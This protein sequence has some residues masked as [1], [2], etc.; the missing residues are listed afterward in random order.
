MDAQYLDFGLVAV[1]DSTCRQLSIFNHSRCPVKFR[2]SQAVTGGQQ[3]ELREDLEWDEKG[4]PKL[5]ALVLLAYMCVCMCASVCVCFNLVYPCA[6]LQDVPCLGFN[7]SD[8]GEIA[9]E[10]G[11]M[12]EVV[13]GPL[14][15]PGHLCTKIQCFIT[16]SSSATV[17]AE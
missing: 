16:N 9:A 14:Q 5:P 3:Q 6:C 4:L 12:V 11:F 10:S 2:L 7:P 15:C 13:C 8:G 17:V 1:G